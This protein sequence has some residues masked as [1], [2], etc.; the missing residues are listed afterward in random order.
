MRRLLDKDLGAQYIHCEFQ[1][2]QSLEGFRGWEEG[3]LHCL[4][5]PQKGPLV[6]V[7]VETWPDAGRQERSALPTVCLGNF[8]DVRRERC[9]R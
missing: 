2:D 9:W 8:L 5:V 7:P 6:K 1:Q 4:C 3:T